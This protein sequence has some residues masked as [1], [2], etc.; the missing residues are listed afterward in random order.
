MAR[1]LP[2]PTLVRTRMTGGDLELWP[3]DRTDA[4]AVLLGI[5]PRPNDSAPRAG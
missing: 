1:R 2:M 4:G 3:S 5:N